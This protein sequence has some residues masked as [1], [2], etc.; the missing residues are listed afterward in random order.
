MSFV[1]LYVLNIS[2]IKYFPVD[3]YD[4]ELN[5]TNAGW[6]CLDGFVGSSHLNHRVPRRWPSSCSQVNK[7]QHVGYKRNSKLA[8][9][10][11]TLIEPS[12]YLSTIID[13]SYKLHC[14]YDVS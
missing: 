8:N 2:S 11:C 4:D 14:G 7:T 1:S 6:L 9:Y 3:I 5:I 13:E 12:S 10:Q